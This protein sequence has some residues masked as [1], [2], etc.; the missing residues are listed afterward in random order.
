M[1]MMLMTIFFSVFSA[2]RPTGNPQIYGSRLDGLLCFAPKIIC[3]IHCGGHKIE[4][5]RISTQ[6][7]QCEHS[8]EKSAWE[9][10]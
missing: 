1:M 8:M 3:E 10:V 5:I 2:L 4:I 7:I 6:N 9:P